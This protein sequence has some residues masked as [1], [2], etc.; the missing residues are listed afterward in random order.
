MVWWLTMLYCSCRRSRV[1]FPEHRCQ[2]ITTC[3]VMLV[4]WIQH[5]FL[6]ST[7]T[8]CM[9]YTDIHIGK[10][11]NIQNTN[12][13]NPNLE[14]PGCSPSDTCYMGRW[15]VLRGPPATCPPALG[16]TMICKHVAETWERSGMVSA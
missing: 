5:P 7:G 15:E 1:Q 3:N 6:T 4:P 14:K 9:W 8:E 10:T 13:K 12:K 16:T 11:P 2:L